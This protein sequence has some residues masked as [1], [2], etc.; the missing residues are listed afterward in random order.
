M[1]NPL[2][3]VATAVEDAE[4]LDTV[5]RL[6]GPALSMTVRSPRLR[7][8]LHG[9]W[10]GHALHPLLTDFPLGM[11][12]SGTLL[13][14][15]GGPQAAPAARRL[16]GLGVLAALPTALTGASEWAAV[17]TRRD[18]RTGLVHAGINTTALGLYAASWRQRVRGRRAGGMALALAGGLTATAGGFFGGHL[19]EVRKVSSRHPAFEH[20]RP[21]VRGVPG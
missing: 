4:A 16:I 20:D 9:H 10:L 2:V 21:T 14:I 19:T 1:T 13:D 15:V 18:R 3:R 11:W 5:D 8:I 12:L 17:D 6:V 7:G